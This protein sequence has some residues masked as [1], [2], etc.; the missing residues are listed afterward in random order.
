MKTHL[1]VKRNWLVSL[2]TKYPYY[3]A[4]N[5]KRRFINNGFYYN[6]K[7]GSDIIGETSV[8]DIEKYAYAGDRCKNCMA[9]KIYQG[10]VK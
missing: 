7:Q 6:D 10:D 8:E 1:M 5:S 4:C 2:F 9:T 3:M